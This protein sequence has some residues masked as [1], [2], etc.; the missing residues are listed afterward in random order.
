M[1]S[2]L[3]ALLFAACIIG[4]TQ[5]VAQGNTWYISPYGNNSNN[6]TVPQDPFL[7]LRAALDAASPGDTIEAASG[8]YSGSDNIDLTL[9]FDVTLEGKSE[10][11][12][13]FQST[14]DENMYRIA[15][16]NVV[17]S[18][19][20]LVGVSD[21]SAAGVDVAAGA[22]FAADSVTFSSL[23]Y[24]IYYSAWAAAAEVSDC[25]FSA[26]TNFGVM[27][28]ADSSSTVTLPSMSVSDSLFQSR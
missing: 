12:T 27:V 15:T 1:K 23:Y 10:G 3:S 14:V 2:A 13:I 24:G 11:S 20:T 7:T 26:S 18:K 8:V 9:G 6:G 5:A 16:A 28:Y 21:S 25:T 22:G 19:V 17:F 4:A